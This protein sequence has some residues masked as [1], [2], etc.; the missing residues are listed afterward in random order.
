MFTQYQYLFLEVIKNWILKNLFGTSARWQS[1]RCQLWASTKDYN[2]IAY[3]PMKIVLGRGL[4]GPVTKLQQNCG[5]KN[6]E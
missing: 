6:R 3:L 1:K 5:I 2:K 4:K